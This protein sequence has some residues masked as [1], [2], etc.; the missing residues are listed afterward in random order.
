MIN[1]IEPD[2]KPVRFVHQLDYAT[3]GVL[4]V[5]LSKASTAKACR[6]FETG[7]VKKTYLAL[8]EGHLFKNMTI[9][10]PIGGYE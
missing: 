3:S 1:A 7:A 4:L 10:E 6:V 8:L 9:N 2:L 5:G